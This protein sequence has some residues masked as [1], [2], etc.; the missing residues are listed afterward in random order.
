MSR[1]RIYI[2]LIGAAAVAVALAIG[3]RGRGDD[4]PAEAI[5]AVAH[6]IEHEDARAACRRLIPIGALPEP[7]LM[8]L[9]SAAPAAGTGKAC[10][11]HFDGPA[12][13]SSFGFT[14]AIVSDVRQQPLAR[15]DQISGLAVANVRLGGA[16]A[17]PVRLVR[18]DGTWKVVVAD[19]FGS[20][21]R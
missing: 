21:V 2:G 18:H 14:D 12:E 6:A 17:I 19:G 20:V 1:R 13:F 7:V 16:A 5:Y 10:L 9:N 11:A 8:A 4:G 15:I 3:L